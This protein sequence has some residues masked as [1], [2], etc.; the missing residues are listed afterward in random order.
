M[1]AA[2]AIRFPLPF[3]LLAAFLN[4]GLLL[5]LGLWRLRYGS[6]SPITLWL[7]VA[8]SAA[9]A[10]LFFPFRILPLRLLFLPAWESGF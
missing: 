9:P 6:F 8:A 3:L 4:L 10:G 1:T 5:G 7:T 2:A